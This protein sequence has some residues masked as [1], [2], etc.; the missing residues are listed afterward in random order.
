MSKERCLRKYMPHPSLATS[1]RFSFFEDFTCQGLFDFQSTFGFQSLF[2]L[3]RVLPFLQSHSAVFSIGKCSN[4]SCEQE[5][6][7]D[8]SLYQCRSWNHY[9]SFL[10]E[11]FSYLTTASSSLSYGLGCRGEALN[12]GP[13]PGIAAASILHFLPTTAHP[14]LVSSVLLNTKHSNPAFS[15]RA[16]YSTS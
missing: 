1:S 11:A 4:Y 3:F 7:L 15:T 2:G 16:N 9:K 12:A 10:K 6:P 8:I 13:D 14:A 5:T